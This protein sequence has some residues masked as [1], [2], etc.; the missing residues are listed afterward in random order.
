MWVWE[1]VWDILVPVARVFSKEGVMEWEKGAIRRTWRYE[2]WV[3][4][5]QHYRPFYIYTYILLV[6]LTWLLLLHTPTLIPLMHSFNLFF[7]FKKM[8]NSLFHFFPFFTHKFY[9]ISLPPSQF[10]SF[11]YLYFIQG[12]RNSYFMLHLIDEMHS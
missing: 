6:I 5:A 1:S 10:Q 12:D 2:A 4:K 7:L 3:I 8:K 9:E 11:F